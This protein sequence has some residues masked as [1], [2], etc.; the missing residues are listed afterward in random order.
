[1]LQFTTTARDFSRALRIVKRAAYGKGA[2]HPIYAS[3]MLSL[4]ARG[5]LSL[6]CTDLENRVD[7]F[8]TVE[9]N[10]PGTCAVDVRSLLGSLKGWK[11]PVSVTLDGHLLRV[12]GSGARFALPSGKKT[13]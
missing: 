8:L 13:D 10:E 11:G 4:G 5:K 12:S 1:M 6:S 9:T 3:V 7:A 2:P